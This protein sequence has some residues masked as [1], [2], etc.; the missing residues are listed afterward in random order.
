[1]T[2]RIRPNRITGLAPLFDPQEGTTV[3]EPHGEGKGYWVGAPSIIYDDDDHTFYLY[4]R[5][6]KPRPV[7]GGEV[8]IASSKDGV[9]FTDI[10]TCKKEELN[11]TSIERSALMKSPDGRWFLYI[12]YVDPKDGRWRTDV[13]E[14]D[15]PDGFQVSQ[16]QKVL[17]ADDIDGEGVKDP[18]V[19]NFGGLYYMILS[20]A[21]KPF[22]KLD[23][24][25]MHGTQ[26]IYNTGITKSSTGLAISTDGIN[27]EWQ[28]DIFSPSESG[29]DSYA[30][31]IGSLL[32]IPPVF[33]AF[34]DG[35][36]SVEE[37]YEERTGLAVSFD[38]RTFHSITP[39]GPRLVSPHGEG[40]L[41][42]LDALQ[43]ENEVW[44][45]YEYTRPDGSH[46]LRMN[47]VPL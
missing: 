27:Y 45:Y 10:W 47:R 12:S 29:W 16:H 30:R 2:D 37:N 44:Y 42:Y 38:L 25:V 15:R 43:M 6:R 3:I 4:Y 41:R 13:V 28:G 36:A 35:S 22:E 32:Y 23:H 31:R 11:T 5:I 9:R 34:Y 24:D 46:E 19:F 26:D 20:Y 39:E 7:R 8:R 18:V 14:S 1:M 33:T 40:S 21:P 17:T